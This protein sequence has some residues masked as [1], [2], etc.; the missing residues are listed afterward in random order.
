MNPYATVMDS[1]IQKSCNATDS[2]SH[3]RLPAG[4]LRPGW[5]EMQGKTRLAALYPGSPGGRALSAA[6]PA[7]SGW[8]GVG[9]GSRSHA[10]SSPSHAVPRLASA[11]A[12]SLPLVPMCARSCTMASFRCGMVWFGVWPCGAYTFQDQLGG[13]TGHEIKNQRRQYGGDVRC[14]PY[15][16]RGFL[17]TVTVRRPAGPGNSHFSSARDRRQPPWQESMDG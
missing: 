6:E 5:G 15:C 13:G 16:G 12:T 2:R 9:V 7:R 14:P 17:I 3:A 8:L 4:Q 11:S 10:V 1:L